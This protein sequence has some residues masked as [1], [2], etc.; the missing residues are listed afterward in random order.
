[1]QVDDA[2]APTTLLLVP[3]AQARQ[4]EEELEPVLELYVPAAQDV[5]A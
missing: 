5:Q 3:G 4:A 1:M 2:V